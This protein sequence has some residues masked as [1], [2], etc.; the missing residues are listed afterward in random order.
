[1]N[2]SFRKFISF[3]FNRLVRKINISANNLIE[4]SKVVDKPRYE[5]YNL[6]SDYSNQP[7]IKQ[8][9]KQ[10][11][12]EK[13]IQ[14]RPEFLPP[15]LI[16][17]WSEVQKQPGKIN[18]KIRIFKKKFLDMFQLLLGLEYKVYN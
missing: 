13:K 14:N 9:R 5:Q 3:N 16:C 6:F 2:S 7:D 4:E 10:E 17:A 15:A 8:I 11:Q 1:M 18:L 12:D